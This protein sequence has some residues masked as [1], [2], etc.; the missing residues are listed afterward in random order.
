ML[1]VLIALIMHDM[2]DMPLLCL[3][4]NTLMRLDEAIGVLIGGNDVL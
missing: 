1:Q 4:Y 3:Q 2:H